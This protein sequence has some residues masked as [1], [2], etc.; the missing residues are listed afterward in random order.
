M[1]GT[2]DQFQLGTAVTRFFSSDLLG[3]G[4]NFKGWQNT[5]EAPLFYC[6]IP[7]LLLMPQVFPFLQKKVRIFF[8]A[9]LAFWLMPIVFPYFRYAFWLFTGDYYRA[10]SIV[11][12]MFL[13]YYALMAL[14]LIIRNRKVNL[15]VLI[16]TVVVL[17]LLLNYPFFPDRDVINSAVFTFV[18]FFI[19]VYGGLLYMLGKKDGPA[20]MKYILLGVVVLELTYMSG[21]TVN[22]RDPITADELTEKKGYND[23]T[24]DALKFIQNSDKSFYRVDKSYASSPAIHFSLNDAQAQ[25]YYGTCGYNPFNQLYYIRYLQLV[26]VSDRKSELDSR[27]ARGLMGR[28]MLESANRVKYMLDKNN[29]VP[30]WRLIGDSIAQFGDVKVFRN[31]LLL[32]FGFTYKQYIKESAYDA[33][34]V[35]QKDFVSLAA[36]VV[37]DEDVS[38]IKGMTEYR[39][40]DTVAP[41]MFTLDLYAQRIA[42][43]G[44]DSMTATTITDTKISG[45]VNL[46]EDKMLYLSV[47]Y[48]GGW[49]LK[50]DGKE[51]PKQIVFAGMTGVMLSRGQHSIEMEYGLRYF[52]KG[53]LMSVLGIVLCA[54]LWFLTRKKG[55]D[56]PQ[57]AT[58]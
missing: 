3:A 24:V 17:F 54:V 30:L 11:V 35:T 48:D 2:V 20:Y 44:R 22:D 36:C 21:I 13:M 8:I 32:P 15:V 18:C 14:D 27:W 55:E 49:T 25:G 5:L 1:F 12:A 23:Y 9:F 57:T 7:C 33:L 58:E 29:A 16:V 6:G 10:Y 56:V 31:R 43:L 47:P 45:K 34:S 52:N 28:P 50:V 39:L 42:D 40:Q 46:P 19:L 37:P 53:L 26:G 51:Q 4:S 38:K 41:S